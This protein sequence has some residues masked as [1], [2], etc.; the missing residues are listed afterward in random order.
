MR[1]EPDASRGACPDRRRLVGVILQGSDSLE[2]N[3]DVLSDGVL[4][5]SPSEGFPL[6]EG[7]PGR[8]RNTLF[9]ESFQASQRQG[10]DVSKRV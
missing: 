6:Y 4:F 2:S 1:V 8:R 3:P 5:H 9:R 7:L 10:R